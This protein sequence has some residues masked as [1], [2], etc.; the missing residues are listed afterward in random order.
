MAAHIKQRKDRGFTWYLVDGNLIR[1][2]GTTKKG[3]AQQRLEQY[4]KGKYG[5]RPTPTVQDYFDKWIEKKI[6]P[7]FRRS[8]VRDYKQ[9]FRAYILPKFKDV[10]L[11]A[12][13]TG[14]LTDF[15]VQLLRHGLSAK[16]AR[17][18]I[19]GSFRRFIG[20]HGQSSRI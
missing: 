6:E 15:R 11:L 19:D 5:L 10:R 4:I 9:H 20:M 18:I 14:E 8:Q 16:T 1:S 17:N 12:I 2:L 3:L 13:G 7:L